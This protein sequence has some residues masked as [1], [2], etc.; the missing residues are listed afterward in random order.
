VE[1]VLDGTPLTINLAMVVTS[2]MERSE[3]II[4]SV[5][6]NLEACGI[7]VTP[8]LQQPVDLYAPGPDGRIVGR[9]F[10]LAQITWMA[11]SEPPCSL[12][13]SDQ[14]PS[15]ENFWIGANV[16]GFTNAAFDQAC[17][18]ARSARPDAFDLYEAGHLEAQRI[19]LEEMPAIPLY[20]NLHAGATRVDFCNFSVNRAAR[21][22][23]WNIEDWDISQTCIEV[24]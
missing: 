10:D 24:E 14:I 6:D 13:L 22:D 21:S 12:Y 23:A 7:G 18:Q 1:G 16:G 5:V 4:N 17:R 11:G 9:N 3:K 2:N 20:F 19:F 15:A 8:V